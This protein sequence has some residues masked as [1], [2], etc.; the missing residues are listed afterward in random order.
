MVFD[1]AKVAP[2]PACDRT[3]IELPREARVEL[4]PPTGGHFL[5]AEDSAEKH[6]LDERAVGVSL[7]SCGYRVGCV[8]HSPSCR[9]NSGGLNFPRAATG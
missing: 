9:S 3:T 4:N 6:G 7:H 8:H 1:Y 5:P 2:N